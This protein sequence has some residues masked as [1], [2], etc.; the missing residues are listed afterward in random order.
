M[1][2]Y[3]PLNLSRLGPIAKSARRSLL[4][5]RSSFHNANYD[6]VSYRAF[7][8]TRASQ[9]R[10]GLRSRIA[11]RELLNYVA[12]AFAYFTNGR[13]PVYSALARVRRAFPEVACVKFRRRIPEVPR[14]NGQ[15]I[16][17]F[18]ARYVSCAYPSSSPPPLCE[19]I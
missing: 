14:G 9:R 11:F 2:S 4:R 18:R 6:R 10:R 3:V 17:A 7:E 15:F 19:R 16:C 5:S 8:K 1:A 13:G 12:P